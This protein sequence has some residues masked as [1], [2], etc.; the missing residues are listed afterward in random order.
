M[1]NIDVL[2]D[3]KIYQPVMDRIHWWNVHIMYKDISPTKQAIIFFIELIEQLLK[4]F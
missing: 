4:N 2:D 3:T 1:F